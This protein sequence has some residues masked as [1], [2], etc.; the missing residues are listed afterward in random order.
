[1]KTQ[2]AVAAAVLGSLL[3]SEIAAAGY[4]GSCTVTALGTGPYYDGICIGSPSKCVFVA[5]DSVTSR[6]LCSENTGWHFVLDLNSASG[7]ETYALLLTAVATG[8]LVGIG[9]TG[10]CSISPTGDV[11]DISYVSLIPP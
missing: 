2:L 4:C 7:R 3:L 8:R 5:V 10:N 1:M 9:G 6:P 11:E